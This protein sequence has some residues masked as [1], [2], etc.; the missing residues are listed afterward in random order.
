MKAKLI[1]HFE[2]FV[3]PQRVA[4]LNKNL[5]FRT[6]YLTA[7]VEDIFQQH[8]ASAIVRTCDCFGIQDLHIIESRNK[9]LPN[10]EIALG[11][12]F[13]VDIHKY[14]S[15]DNTSE[16]I[17]H[18]KNEGYRIVAT[19]L[20]E[21]AVP[22]EK[23]DLNAGKTAFIFGTEL[24]GISDAA[25]NMADEFLTIPMFGFADSFNVSVSAAIVM[26]FLTLQLRQSN[27]AWQLTEEEKMDVKI[28]WLKN[29]IKKPE[30]LEKHFIENYRSSPQ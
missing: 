8:N 9:F 2:Q 4:L 6:R 28:K 30:L 17:Q 23:F 25:K 1:E 14:T 27:L 19:T 24:T 21:K 11:S 10:K 20:H 26:H 12:E 5:S 13:W 3:L 7:V 29:S 18:L 22:L 15:Q 16:A